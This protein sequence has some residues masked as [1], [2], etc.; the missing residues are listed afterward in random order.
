MARARIFARDATAASERKGVSAASP[1]KSVD[2]DRTPQAV[3]ASRRETFHPLA[4]PRQ[5]RASRSHQGRRDPELR[6]SA[7]GTWRCRGG[8]KRPLRESRS[9][10]ASQAATRR[11]RRHFHVAGCRRGFPPRIVAPARSATATTAQQ[12]RWPMTGPGGGRRKLGGRERARARHRLREVA[13]RTWR[14]DDGEDR[15]PDIDRRVPWN[16]AASRASSPLH[17]AG[18]ING[19]SLR[20]AAGRAHASSSPIGWPSARMR[21]GRPL[22]SLNSCRVSIARKR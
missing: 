14:R 21:I 5:R 10:I 11:P 17:A 22:R 1:R 20:A 16:P 15:I 12:S 7:A 13:G 4:E 2:R 18:G 9:R 6:R 8:Q 19:P 3:R